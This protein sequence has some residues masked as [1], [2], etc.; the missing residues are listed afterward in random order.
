MIIHKIKKNGLKEAI[1]GL[2]LKNGIYVS[3]VTPYLSL[4]SFLASLKPFETNHELIRI[5]GDTDG[6]YLIPND[7]QDVDTCFSPGVSATSNFE[8][9]LTEK[10]IKCFLADYSV[11]APPIENPLFNFEKKY[12]GINNDNVFI[13]LESW[14]NQKAPN[15]NELLLQMDIEGAEYPVIMHTSEST[16]SKFRILVIEF[17]GLDMILVKEGYELMRLTFSKLLKNFDILHIHPNNCCGSAQYK[18]LVIPRVMEFT[19]LRK[20]RITYK[21]PAKNFPNPLDQK[22]VATF[23]DIHLPSCWY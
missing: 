23:N 22:N 16:L 12:L 15:K 19:F 18:D 2:L 9:E 11:D 3:K 5:G 4:V 17:H 1:K 21:A 6:G 10:G 20:D 7:L 14:I 8:N 13:T